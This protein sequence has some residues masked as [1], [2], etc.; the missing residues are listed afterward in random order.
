M[1]KTQFTFATLAA[2]LLL[3]ACGSSDLGGILGGGQASSAPESSADIYGTV[4]AVD[5]RNSRIDVT[6][7]NYGGARSI[8]YDTRT[9]V[10]YQGQTGNP[11]QLERGDR[12]SVRMTG[13]GNNAVA[14]LITVTQ[15]VSDTTNSG[16]YPNTN[17]NTY[18]TYP[19]TTNTATGRV[20]GTVNY[21][22]TSAR[23]INLTAS[24]MNVLRNSTNNTYTVYYDAR[25]RVLFQGRTYNVEDL[26]RG[27]QI[28]IATYANGNQY[29]ADT[30]TVVR[31]V[32]Q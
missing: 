3:S 1:R 19:S 32:R 11:S 25:T 17:P 23:L 21:I 28:D 9:R 13:T 24:Y 22:D 26:E 6:L 29:I 4:S 14:D 8:Y 18:P 10:T 12:V 2:I 20:T 15:S 5:T 30:V 31:N 7:D 16:N 27:D